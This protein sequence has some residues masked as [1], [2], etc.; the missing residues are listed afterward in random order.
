M[1]GIVKQSE[2]DLSEWLATEAGFIT[3]FGRY[4][5]E[6][7]TL[8]PYQLAF[9][10]NTSRFRW[11]TKSRQV[12]L[13]FLLA[14]EALA[15]CH[16]RP[17]HTSVFVSYNLS[18]ATEKILFA[19]H[20]YEELPLAYQKKLVV[21]SKTELAFES[22]GAHHGLSRIIS[23][24]SKAPRGKKGDVLLDE[25][26]HYVLDRE[27]YSGSTA[28]ILRSGN[29]LTGC[30][31]PLGR[32]GIFWEIATQELRAYPHHWRQEVPWWL[33]RFF[34]TDTKTAAIEA[35]A[36]LTE[37]RIARFGNA[38]IV[39][40]YDSLA[41]DDFQQE[42]ECVPPGSLVITHGGVTPIESV[43]E[44]DVVLT[45]TG[46]LQPVLRTMHRHHVGEI[47]RVVTYHTDVPLRVTAEHPVL[48]TE[49]QPCVYER[50]IRCYPT[51]GQ[52]CVHRPAQFAD[53]KFVPAGDLTLRHVLMYPVPH[54]DESLAPT[55][56][57]VR[58]WF[59]YPRSYKSKNRIPESIPITNAM[60][61]L[62]GY[63]L[64]EGSP[65]AKIR[66]TEFCFH[67]EETDMADEVREAVRELFGLRSD[68]RVVENSLKVGVNSVVFRAIFEGLFGGLQP[69]RHIP[70][71]WMNL[72]DERLW[73]LASAYFNGD[74]CRV[75][76]AY[77]ASTC[78]RVLAYQL[79]DVLVRRGFVPTVR[80]SAEA[81]PYQILGTSGTSATQYEV[82][83]HRHLTEDRRGTR[84]WNDGLYV[85]LP[86][87][88]IARE[89][90]DGPVHNLSVAETESYV[91]GCHAVHNCTS[92]DESYSYY[93]YELI[94]P[95]TVDALPLADDVGAIVKPTG[96]LVAGFDVGRT[97]DRSE[98][99]VF[100][101]I[102]GIFICRYL[103][104]FVGTP[105]AEQEGELRRLLNTVPIV[106][107]SIDR[108]GIGMNLAENLARDY[109]QVVEENF[110]NEAKE[111]W[112]TDMKITL[113]KRAIQLPRH[114][115]LIA[116]FHSIKRKVLGS[117]KVSFDAEKTK[118]GHAD[119]FWACALACQKER[120]PVRHA[121]EIGCRILE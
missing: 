30:S 17:K 79:R 109:P 91:L 51:C 69:E 101:E 22:N 35:P 67:A 39:Q 104:S 45:H 100:E 42:F 16:L 113:Q 58:D 29:Q 32:R 47:V 111:R 80:T 60:L 102:E 76:S 66:R 46:E 1:L 20:V 110:T 11:V 96:R 115:D 105:F 54:T 88:Q 63:Y 7:I 95:C 50:Q 34:C 57:N 70:P 26:A 40:Q 117:G 23:H 13:S 99:A 84:G 9:L 2:S 78:S 92:V 59:Q 49:L 85:Y 118:N 65:N 18:D 14:L 41:L 81:G 82:R 121:V 21:D 89:S 77:S 68:V 37:E 53:P 44:G 25:L 106:R 108:N 55:A 73:V 3:A 33:C 12:G 93:P 38:D 119:R 114:R 86:I 8:E 71:S 94:L 10:A 19:R 62:A 15:R 116:Q 5:D 43:R 107:L 120:Q 4:D 56:V 28:L 83:V 61:R 103:R 98:L 74:G 90:Y 112:A 87:S 36:M 31:T 64:A 72:P 52:G 27:V 75:P 6:P 48:A 97:R 24:P